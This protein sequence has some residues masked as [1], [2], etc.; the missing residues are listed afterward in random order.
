MAEVANPVT[1]S[2]AMNPIRT[3]RRHMLEDI[4]RHALFHEMHRSVE[5]TAA[6]VTDCLMK[7]SPDLT[8]PP[9]NGFSAD[10]AD[11]LR[12]IPKTDA[13]ARA[14]RKLIADA[15]SYPMFHLL[16]LADGVV[17]PPD[18]DDIEEGDHSAVQIA[19]H[20]GFHESY[21]AWRRRRPDPGWRLD[22]YEGT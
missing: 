14:L 3:W 12:S 10:E 22:N 2:S 6:V 4:N 15:A 11:A 17:D 13:M 9:N 18:L 5:E 1:I 20:D 16:C 21:W 7:G 19:L 8:Y